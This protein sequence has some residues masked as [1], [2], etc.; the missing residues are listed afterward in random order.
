VILIRCI[1]QLTDLTK[2]AAQQ[3]GLQVN[4]DK[5]NGVKATVCVRYSFACV[6]KLQLIEW[7][8]TNRNYFMRL[9]FQTEVSSNITA[10]WY[11][12]AVWS[13]RGTCLFY[14]EVSIASQEVPHPTSPRSILILSTHLCLGLPSGLFPSGFPPII[15]KPSSSLP[16]LLHGPPI[17]SSSTWLF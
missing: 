4:T 15:Y 17:S 12:T 1:Y 16:F 14:F 6:A 11:V 13:G 3:T 9:V 8:M 2:L 5:G 10:F 7:A